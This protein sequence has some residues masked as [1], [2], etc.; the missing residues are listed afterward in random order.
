MEKQEFDVY[1]AET[2]GWQQLPAIAA[3]Q[4]L[5]WAWWL[6]P[7]I[8]ALWEAEVGGSQ[9]QKIETILANMNLTL[10]PRLECSGVILAHCNLSLPGSTKI[11]GTCHHAWLI[12][13]F[14]V[15]TEFCHVGQAGPKLLTS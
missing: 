5:G 4:V 14:S 2:D 6:M 7:V 10:S 9:G 3:L 15:D 1:E 8:P 13:V 11:T 12:F